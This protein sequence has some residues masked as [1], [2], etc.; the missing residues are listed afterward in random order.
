MSALDSK[1][2]ELECRIRRRAAKMG[3]KSIDELASGTSAAVV[4]LTEQVEVEVARVE[5]T[6]QVAEVARVEM[7]AEQV[8]EAEAAAQADAAE[9]EAEAAVCLLQAGRRRSDQL[10]VDA[11]RQQEAL[12]ERRAAAKQ[13][14]AD[15]AAKIAAN[16][17]L[18]K[19]GRACNCRL[20]AVPACARVTSVCAVQ[21][22]ARMLSAGAL[23]G[24]GYGAGGGRTSC[25]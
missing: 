18:S 3:T 17:T 21:G 24:H 25:M 20:P 1:M 4:E 6:E 7:V 13:A 2:E 12:R 15:Q 22:T 19:V 16:R 5:L 11:R 10:Y 14:E 8:A 23:S 9:A